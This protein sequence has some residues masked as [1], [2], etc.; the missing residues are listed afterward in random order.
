VR[1][2]LE[3]RY[4]PH[5][6]I[7]PTS[8]RTAYIAEGNRLVEDYLGVLFRPEPDE[9]LPG[10]PTEVSMI[11]AYFTEGPELYKAVVSGATFTLREGPSIVGYGVVIQRSA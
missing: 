9:L 1:R 6:V 7:G 11:L 4:R 8:Q 10:M 2:L 5:I 3:W